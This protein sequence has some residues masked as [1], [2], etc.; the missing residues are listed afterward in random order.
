MLPPHFNREK[1]LE[2]FEGQ[3]NLSI[4]NDP[5]S[6][7]ICDKYY[8][9]NSVKICYNLSRKNSVGGPTYILIFNRRI[10]INCYIVVND[11]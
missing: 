11:Y 3:A 2:N 5:N 6:K 4:K 1:S 9:K 7:Q 8:Y 10:S